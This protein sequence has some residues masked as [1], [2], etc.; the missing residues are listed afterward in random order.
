LD[1]VVSDAK[2]EVE[3]GV[4]DSVDALAPGPCCILGASEVSG[5]EVADGAVGVDVVDPEAIAAS[6]TGVVGVA[7]TE[8]VGSVPEV[9]E[10]PGGPG[11]GVSGTGGITNTVSGITDQPG[12]NTIPCGNPVCCW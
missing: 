1:A 2:D 4:T 3:V 5:A 7:E 11:A 8:A 9:P 12:G 10:V 6:G